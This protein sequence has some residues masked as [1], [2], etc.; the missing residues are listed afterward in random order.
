MHGFS[1]DNFLHCNIGSKISFFVL[2]IDSIMLREVDSA[3]QSCFNAPISELIKAQASKLP[4]ISHTQEGN[5]NAK[6]T[7]LECLSQPNALPNSEEN[8]QAQPRLLHEKPAKNKAFKEAKRYLTKT[9]FVFYE[10][11]FLRDPILK[12]TKTTTDASRE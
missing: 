2:D 11:C 1:P 7:G 4:G 12:K 5:E 6:I 8:L 3:T 9:V 10:N